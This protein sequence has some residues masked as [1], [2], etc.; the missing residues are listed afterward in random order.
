MLI[1]APPFSGKN[2]SV[3]RKIKK[4]QWWNTWAG[5]SALPTPV[6]TL[7]DSLMAT[8]PLKRPTMIDIR[9]QIRLIERSLSRPTISS[10]L[11]ELT[12]AATALAKRIEKTEKSKTKKQKKRRTSW[13][14]AQSS[15][16]PIVEE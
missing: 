15:L 13:H 3:C 12:I 10:S 5:L 8:N 1:G 4:G 14:N 2:G 9:Q 11:E 16:K 7:L 6:I